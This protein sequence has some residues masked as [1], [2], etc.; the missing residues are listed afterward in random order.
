MIQKF[1]MSKLMKKIYNLV[2][3]FKLFS[4]I[5]FSLLFISCKLPRVIEKSEKIRPEWVYGISKDYVIVEGV[6]ATWELAQDNALKKIKERIVSSV[7][8]NISSETNMIVTEN[9]INNMS[10]YSESTELTTNI[11]TDF[12]NSLKGISLNKAQTFYWERQLY[13]GKQKM[14]H[15]HIKYPFSQ[16]ELDELIAEWEKT[17]KGFTAEIDKIEDGIDNATSI[18]ELMILGKKITELKDIF[19]GTRRSRVLILG[20]EINQILNNLK[21]EVQ[22]HERGQIIIKLISSDRYFKISNELSFNAECAV[23]QDYKVI[24]DDYTM[25]INYDADFCYSEEKPFF[26]ISQDYENGPISSRWEIPAGKN[27][28]RLTVNEPIRFKSSNINKNSIKW[29]VPIRVY[30]DKPFKVTKV[31]LVVSHNSRIN[32]RKFI[33]GDEKETYV[34]KDINQNFKGKGDYS[35]QFEVPQ[36][37]S[38]SMLGL[39]LNIIISESSTFYAAGK[40]YIIPENEETEYVFEF[41]NKNIIR[42]E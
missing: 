4:L 26:T 22:K 5:L 15:Y 25:E 31:E 24:E 38:S 8:V 13:P 30:T 11:S 42:I 36:T 2:I 20:S 6:G 37:S 9:V 3:Q 29:Y 14:V 33:G 10:R 23:L 39:I 16:S 18:S 7:A 35:L 41:E 32:I 34:I 12:F 21:Y 28:V 17:D 19:T 27:Q 40:I 1:Q